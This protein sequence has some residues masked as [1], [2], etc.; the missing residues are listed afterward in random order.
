LID[1]YPGRADLFETYAAQGLPLT[2]HNYG[3]YRTPIDYAVYNF[4]KLISKH[5]TDTVNNLI[6]L[7]CKL[8]ANINEY[9]GDGTCPLIN[10]YNAYNNDLVKLLLELG[11]DDTQYLVYKERIEEQK[12]A[13]RERIAE[14]DRREKQ[15]RINRE[16]ERKRTE[17]EENRKNITRNIIGPLLA[18]VPFILGMAL[19]YIAWK[20]SREDEA[21]LLGIL[22]P[23]LICM[24]I[25]VALIYFRKLF[26]PSIIIFV[27]AMAVIIAVLINMDIEDCRFLNSINIPKSV[28]TIENRAFQHC[29]SLTSVT[30]ESGSVGL[31]SGSGWESF[32]GDL[33]QKYHAG[34]IGTY[35]R[36]RDS[37]TWTKKR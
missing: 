9:S 6:R 35:T 33:S 3:D 7:L 5:G 22:I 13:E 23:S 17:A 15:E 37:G 29:D 28:T 2:G 10:A 25:P 12:R 20:G 30:F 1:S 24:G 32:V 8:R 26:V 21:V 16:I 34:G 31:D 19:Y 14:Q 11:A 18:F 36:P 4:I 27:L